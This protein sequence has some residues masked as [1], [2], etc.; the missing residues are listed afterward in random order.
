MKIDQLYRLCAESDE[1]VCRIEIRN[2]AFRLRKG[3]VGRIAFY[4]VGGCNSA[5][6]AHVEGDPNLSTYGRLYAFDL[7]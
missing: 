3:G 6:A 2:P 4:L 1:S 5:T 7:L